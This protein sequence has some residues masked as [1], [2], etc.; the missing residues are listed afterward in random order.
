M[1]LNAL[2]YTLANRTDRHIEALQLIEQ[3][4]QLLPDNP[5][6]LDSL[7]W[8]LYR[9][10]KLE[11]SL[12]YLEKAWKL[13]PDAEVAAHLGEVLWAVG[14]KKE[15]EKVWQEALNSSPDNAVLNETI[16]RFNDA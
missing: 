11:D 10:G 15:A 4:N 6:I 5:A 13:Y 12:H 16:Q 14:Q 2:G 9:L 8:A 7:G 3:A 1:A